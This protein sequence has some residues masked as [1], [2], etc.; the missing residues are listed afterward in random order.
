MS[1]GKQDL[2]SEVNEYCLILL[3]PFYTRNVINKTYTGFRVYC[4]H[5][6]LHTAINHKIKVYVG[7]ADSHVVQVS[8]SNTVITYLIV[9]CNN[10]KLDK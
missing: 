6:T 7:M 4:V 1:C 9:M 10:T 2:C 8:C 3:S 5:C